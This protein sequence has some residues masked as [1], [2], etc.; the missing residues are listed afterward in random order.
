MSGKNNDSGRTVGKECGGRRSD[1]YAAAAASSP[2]AAS[3]MQMF[4]PPVAG[5][6]Q[7][8]KSAGSERSAQSMAN[9]SSRV[10]SER[11]AAP[12]PIPPRP[13]SSSPA[14]AQLMGLFATPTGSSA[15]SSSS[16]APKKTT[17]TA[18]SGSSGEFS[19]GRSTP[20]AVVPPA[21]HPPFPNRPAPDARES[22]TT[23][24]HSNLSGTVAA[25]PP[26]PLPPFM[27]IRQRSSI[28]DSSTDDDMN[29]DGDVKALASPPFGKTP[30]T[31]NF[32]SHL[33]NF[34][35]GL[36]QRVLAD[37]HD[38]RSALLVALAS[39]SP[40]RLLAPTTGLGTL[41]D[42]FR[43]PSQPS[44]RGMVVEEAKRLEGC[45]RDGAGAVVRNLEDV[46]GGYAS[47][48]ESMANVATPEVRNGVQSV[49]D[50]PSFFRREYLIPIKGKPPFPK[51]LTGAQKRA[52]QNPFAAAWSRLRFNVTRE[53]MSSCVIGSFVFVLYHVVFCLAMASSITRPSHSSDEPS[54]MLAPMAQMA[55][56]GSL[57]ANPAFI[58][59]LGGD[60]PALYP[61]IDLFLAPFAANLAAAVDQAFVRDGVEDDG[62]T[63]FLAT[64]SA[65]NCLG[66]LMTALLCYLASQFKLAN[67]GAFLPY[68]VICGFFSAVGIQM[69][70]LA[71]S[72]DTSLK[73][74]DVLLSGN[75][76]VIRNCLVHHIP[77]LCVAV[78]M[79]ILG[80]KKPWLTPVLVLCTVALGYLV[81]L[82]TGTSLSQAQELGWFWT[83]E[84]F[85]LDAGGARIGS[86]SPP[87]PFGIVPSI[88]QG[89]VHIPAL[90]AGLPSA[91]AMA[92]VYLLRCSIHAAALKKNG[93]NLL[94]TK[95]VIPPRLPAP[96][97]G[98]S[99]EKIPSQGDEE[100]GGRG[101]GEAITVGIL[102]I[103]RCYGAGI[104]LSAIIG[105][106]GCLPSIAAGSSMF[107]LGTSGIAPQY[108]SNILLVAFYL[109]N[110]APVSVIPKPAFSCLILLAFIDL[111]DV[112]L[113]R[114]YAKT[115]N[116]VEW[117]V[118]PVIVI[119]SFVIGMLQSVALGI[120]LS[121]FV[122]VAAFYRT[123]V[124]RY[125]ANGLTIR[126]TIE[127]S[128]RDAD[129]LDQNGDLIQVLVLQN[130][131]FFGNA[132]SCLEYVSQ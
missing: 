38:E 21:P 43:P 102:K 65:L 34:Q 127:R 126:S 62:G 115:K 60:L 124:V 75:W 103:M 20:R 41:H 18:A 58:F 59:L 29:A 11:D 17:A 118:V 114:S 13:R 116:K 30:P 39:A 31:R 104:C 90:M 12:T 82:F 105:G 119:F 42:M 87:L 55:A 54:Q 71:F 99:L 48:S 47:L 24:T 111:I 79:K 85:M 73:V 121:T 44:G 81:M 107:K 2:A 77:S 72:V 66:L 88:F 57:T 76:A 86:W 32:S 46:G 14:A 74:R 56:L 95:T 51:N 53:A 101:A 123:G 64:F 3:L 33:R 80:P 94:R 69:W 19:S 93:A 108:G 26:P 113:V 22:E 50:S 40:E 16:L 63:A 52:S 83:K 89:K 78:L 122:F 84:E 4:A 49:E 7:R 45:V 37:E 6:S 91:V 100:E 120:A 8:E 130:Y 25:P 68:S 10:S 129:W 9:G 109:S 27:A 67:L 132:S 15:L 35:S 23:E 117:L 5:A 92:A 28:S 125:I 36:S 110:F 98:G 70:I 97:K 112:W 106:F 128:G 96:P 131:L 1:Q 61:C